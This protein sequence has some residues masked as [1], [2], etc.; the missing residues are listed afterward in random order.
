MKLFYYLL[1]F[2]PLSLISSQVSAQCTGCDRVISTNV[3]FSVASGEKVCL[4]FTGTFT[5]NIDFSGN[6]T[7]CVSSNTTVSNSIN[8][9]LNGTNNSFEN[10]GTWNKNLNLGNNNSFNNFGN[11]SVGSLTV[12]NNSVFTSTT[13]VTVTGNTQND[14][15]GTINITGDFSTG[16]YTGGNNSVLNVGGDMDAINITTGGDVVIGGTTSAVNVTNNSGG[17]IVFGS[18]GT[19]SGAVQNNG[20]ME[21]GGDTTI[22]GSFTNNGNG[23]ITVDNSVVSVGGAFAN[24]GDIVALGSCGRINIAG[25]SVN[26]GSGNVGTD[27]SNVDICDTSSS[28]GGSFDSNGGNIGPNVSNCTCVPTILPITLSSFTANK[29]TNNSVYINWETVFELDNQYFQIE[30]SFSG[31]DFKIITQVSSQNNNQEPNKERKYSFIDNLTDNTLSLTSSNENIY[32]R[33]KQIDTNGNFTYSP[34]VVVQVE[35]NDTKEIKLV[36]FQNEWKFVLQN[37]VQVK[38]YSS[39][40]V[41][42]GIHNLNQNQNIISVSSLSKGMYILHIQDSKTSKMTVL[43][44]VR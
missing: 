5:G 23:N 44:V 33:L 40:G 16:N 14:N 19:I 38:I 41:L 25:S 7:L 4:T 15:N 31:T 9:N 17:S 13:D 1:L 37:P 36:S 42:K 24:N 12:G 3:S 27:G 34:V 10:Y 20:D 39:I 22:G 35:K 28:N 21:F 26:N 18:G 43:K 8:M 32:Y 11:F 6:G 30:R 29:E 2:I